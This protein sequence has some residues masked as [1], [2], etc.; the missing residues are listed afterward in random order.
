MRTHLSKRIDGNP[1]YSLRAYAKALEVDVSDLSKVFSNKKAL[2]IPNAEKVAHKLG[3]DPDEKDL[4][5]FSVF[6]DHQNRGR[7]K[8]IPQT[9]AE[10]AP[11]SERH[12][13]QDEFR[14]IA[15]WYHAAIMELTF[16]VNIPAHLPEAIK[17]CS[18]RLGVSST[19]AKVALERLMSLG[20]LKEKAG[21]LVKSDK[22]LTVKNRRI[23]DPA[24][25]KFLQQSLVK[26]NEALETTPIE[27]RKMTVMTLAIDPKKIEEAKQLIDDFKL[28]MMKFLE[29]GASREVYHMGIQLYPVELSRRE[30]SLPLQEAGNGGIQ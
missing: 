6:T 19:E 4:F 27:A 16:A 28:K 25:K 3:L 5:M 17:L 15:D 13:H 26:A 24:R 29:T 20:F 9:F 21:Y 14:A 12:L 22:N 1:R 18:Q 2:S 10:P 30:G 23:T 11:R 8:A 7:K